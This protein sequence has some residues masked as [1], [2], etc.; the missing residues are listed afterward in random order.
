MY[1]SLVQWALNQWQ[2]TPDWF[3]FTKATMQTIRHNMLCKKY[4]CSAHVII[5]N[6][7]SVP[8]LTYLN[9][10][11]KTN[12]QKTKQ[13]M[14]HKAQNRDHHIQIIRRFLQQH[15]IILQ[16]S[17]LCHDCATAWSQSCTFYLFLKIFHSRFS[18]VG[19][20]QYLGMKLVWMDKHWRQRREKN[21]EFPFVFST[22]LP[23]TTTDLK[24]YF[25]ISGHHLGALCRLR[26][27][28]VTSRDGK[29]IG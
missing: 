18:S 8:N 21:R 11:K 10:Y 29:H 5:V 14:V 17:K 27:A 3:F 19:P 25:E 24:F 20:G 7:S 6:I 16:V 22:P 23:A 26:R 4:D 28:N 12:K 15:H 1:F 2:S 9:T 13:K